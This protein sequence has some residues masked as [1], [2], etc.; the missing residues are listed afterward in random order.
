M[1]TALNVG[2]ITEETNKQH[3]STIKELK[4]LPYEYCWLLNDDETPSL[5]G[6]CNYFVLSLLH[7][8]VSVAC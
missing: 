3:F 4:K 5:L 1:N 2:Y 6:K 7:Y 8:L